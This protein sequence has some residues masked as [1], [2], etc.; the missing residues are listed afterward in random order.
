MF[1]RL[2]NLYEQVNSRLNYGNLDFNSMSMQKNTLLN[3]DQMHLNV[4]YRLGEYVNR[5]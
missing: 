3:S 4:H 2:P 5:F 1:Q